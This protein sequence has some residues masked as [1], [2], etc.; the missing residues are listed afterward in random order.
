MKKKAAIYARVSTSDKQDYQRQINELT[1]IAKEH[2]YEDEN[3]INF[4]E[5]V[6]GYKKNDERIQL[7]L[8]QQK[9]EENP[10]FFGCI[11]TS[12]ISR[13]G[14]NPYHT[15]QVIDRWSELGIPLY[16]QSLKQST[17]DSDGNRNSIMNII[18]QVLMEYANE[19][20]KTFVIRS[21]SGLL[22]S[23]RSGKAGGGRYYKSRAI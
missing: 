12:E 17:I 2:G 7:S 21:K 20:A 9:I 19:E 22:N 1:L 6:S 3:I 15:R 4:A 18:L 10:K 23:A 5:S 16:I 8:L 14:R 13:I 11:Y